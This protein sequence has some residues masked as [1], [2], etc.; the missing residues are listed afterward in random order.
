MDW[1]TRTKGSVLCTV[2]DI[3]CFKS[4]KM[5]VL[6]HSNLF[7]KEQELEVSDKTRM[8]M[9]LKQTLMNPLF[10]QHLAAYF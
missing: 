10:L 2:N 6:M 9:M 4:L 1:P 8:M 7:N 3:G 5:F